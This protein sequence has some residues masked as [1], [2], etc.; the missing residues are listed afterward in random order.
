M[1]RLG[2]AYF[3]PLRIMGN[4]GKLGKADEHVFTPETSL[5]VRRGNAGV[6]LP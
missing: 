4:L 5:V 6:R 1:G 2:N 3:P